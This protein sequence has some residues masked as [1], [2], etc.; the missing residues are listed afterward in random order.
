MKTSEKILA[1]LFVIFLIGILVVGYQFF[2]LAQ[3]L[4][5]ILSFCYMIGGYYFFNYKDHN[6]A[7]NITAGIILGVTLLL[8][9]LSLWIP[10][11]DFRKAIV[12]I[13]II[14]Y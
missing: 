11:S 14:F 1:T 3:C 12:V 10:V 8:F 4:S 7:L 5:F 6:H 2:I 13:N 9:N